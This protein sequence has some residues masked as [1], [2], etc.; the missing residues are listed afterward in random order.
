M[1]LLVTSRFRRDEIVEMLHLIMATIASATAETGE[2]RLVEVRAEVI[3]AHLHHEGVDLHILG[4]AVWIDFHPN[5][6]RNLQ[7]E[8]YQDNVTLVELP[9]QTGIHVIGA[10][11]IVEA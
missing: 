1:V 5:I 3:A 10:H 6:K 9:L 7:G 2:I 11:Q 4:A 8:I